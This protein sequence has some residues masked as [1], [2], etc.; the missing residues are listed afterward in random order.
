MESGCLRLRVPSRKCVS[1]EKEKKRK[2]N[3]QNSD[4]QCMS[5]FAFRAKTRWLCYIDKVFVFK[6]KRWVNSLN[7]TICAVNK[8]Y[9]KFSMKFRTNTNHIYKNNYPG[10]L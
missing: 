8:I 7:D 9:S 10:G 1:L 3:A 5:V 2:R 6:Y 4:M